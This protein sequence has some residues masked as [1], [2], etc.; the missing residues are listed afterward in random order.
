M[1]DDLMERALFETGPPCPDCGQTG[2]P[3][4][5]WSCLHELPN[6]PPDMV[7]GLFAFDDG[8]VMCMDC[9]ATIVI[10]E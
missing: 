2:C 6:L 1:P 10:G 9:H 8:E 7:P 5:G 4:C 3:W